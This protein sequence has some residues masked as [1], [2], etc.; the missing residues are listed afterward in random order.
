M[1]GEGQPDNGA[2]YGAHVEAIRATGI[3]MRRLARFILNNPGP[4][5]SAPA[6]AT[7]SP[8]P[9]TKSRWN[10]KNRL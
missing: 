6:N 1:S 4:A 2:D 8:Q 9:R 5:A 7:R 10:G 3:A